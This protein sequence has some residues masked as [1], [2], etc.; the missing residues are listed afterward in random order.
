MAIAPK[1]TPQ[2]AK[3]ALAQRRAEADARARAVIEALRH[4][5]DL[6]RHQ[7]AADALEGILTRGTGLR[8][9]TLADLLSPQPWAIDADGAVLGHLLTMQDDV[10]LAAIAEGRVDGLTL[11]EAFGLLW[12][13]LDERAEWTRVYVETLRTL[14]DDAEGQLEAQ[15]RREALQKSSGLTGKGNGNEHT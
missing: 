7:A 10:Y 6:R 12:S 14:A 5:G 13:D 2:E 9:D 4:A 3:A 1:R 15:R 11:G 8:F